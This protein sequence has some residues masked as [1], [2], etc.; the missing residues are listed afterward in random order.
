MKKAIR[1]I[2]AVA[3]IVS[4]FASCASKSEKLVGTWK[5]TTTV[6]SVVTEHKYVFNAD[7]TG[8]TP[9]ETGI[10]NLDM[11]Y[12]VDGNKLTI[13]T[14]LYGAKEYTFTVKR[15]TLSLTDA[16]GKTLK[17]TKAE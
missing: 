11:K 16:D 1:I 5:Y 13:K 6:F 9:G 15:K 7:G 3:L 14:E 8:K 2:L 4:A 12:S 17:L 10:F